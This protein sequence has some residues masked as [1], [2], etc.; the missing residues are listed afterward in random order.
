M[1]PGG[2]GMQRI[3]SNES[4]LHTGGASAGRRGV[5]R[6]SADTIKDDEVS[7]GWP[8]LESSTLLSGTVRM[9]GANHRTTYLVRALPQHAP[10]LSMARSAECR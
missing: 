1:A 7:R 4:S 10:W 5:K 3:E 6:D 9:P 8:L 2:R